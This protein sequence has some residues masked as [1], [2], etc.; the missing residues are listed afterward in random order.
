MEKERTLCCADG[1]MVGNCQWRGG[2]GLGMPCFS[3]CEIDETELIQSTCY[4]LDMKSGELDC[5]G[6]LML[7]F[8]ALPSQLLLVGSVPK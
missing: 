1:T 2:R 5:L 7:V 3:G 8:A 4:R 6:T